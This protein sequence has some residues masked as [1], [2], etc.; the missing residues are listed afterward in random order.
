MHWCCQTLVLIALLLIPLMLLALVLDRYGD[1][2][3]VLTAPVLTGANSTSVGTLFFACI[4]Q[5]LAPAGK[6]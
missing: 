1:I 6:K 3:M 2:D 4:A 5:K